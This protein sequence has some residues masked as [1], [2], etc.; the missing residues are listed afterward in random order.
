M[1]QLTRNSSVPDP[2]R[3]FRHFYPAIAWAILILIISGIPG[4]YIP[5]SIPFLNLFKPD[6]LVHLFL[7]ATFSYLLS[8]GSEK[9]FPSG[10]IATKIFIS[11]GTGIVFG[12][13]TEALQ[14]Y[15]FIGRSG[16]WMDFMADVTGCLIGWA[17]FKVLYKKD[18]S[19]EKN[20]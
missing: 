19:S 2:Q 7:F 18:E 16:N 11:I 5:A 10:S 6:K 3:K 13:L 12:L 14:R 20:I 9:Y 17:I 15:L 1:P 8:R 4:E